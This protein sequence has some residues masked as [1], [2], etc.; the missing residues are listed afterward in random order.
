MRSHSQKT[1]SKPTGVVDQKPSE[2]HK[3]GSVSGM[4]RHSLHQT[5]R[6]VKSDKARKWTT[7]FSNVSMRVGRG[8]EDSE[9]KYIVV[10]K[11]IHRSNKIFKVKESNLVIN[12][13]KSRNDL[14]GG[15]V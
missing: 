1:R 10:K 14:Q 2:E 7:E 6:A 12:L 4:C 13:T 8:S 9:Y 15:N 11:D 5:L 3:V